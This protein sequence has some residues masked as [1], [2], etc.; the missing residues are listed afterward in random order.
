MLTTIHKGTLRPHFWKNW[1]I[2]EQVIKRENSRKIRGVR[3]H[4]KTLIF[5]N[6]NP[7]F[8]VYDFQRFR[9]LY[10]I[11]RLKK[12]L[13]FGKTTYEKRFFEVT[14]IFKKPL[15][16]FL[17]TKNRA[18]NSSPKKEPLP[19]PLNPGRRQRHKIHS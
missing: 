5:K 15:F 7:Y 18:I 13:Q 16:T 9:F 11:F 19:S 1:N 14:K 2:G 8:F 17:R 4:L 10:T 12:P 6:E 3:K